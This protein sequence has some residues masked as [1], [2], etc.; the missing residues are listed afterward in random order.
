MKNNT[1]KKISQIPGTQ[2]KKKKKKLN[3]FFENRGNFNSGTS[4]L[5]LPSKDEKN[6]TS[7]IGVPLPSGKEEPLVV[8]R[9]GKTEGGANASYVKLD[10]EEGVF[11]YI[12]SVY[13]SK[14]KQ[15]NKQTENWVETRQSQ[16][17]VEEEKTSGNSGD[18]DKCAV[19]SE[20]AKDC[21]LSQLNQSN[22][23]K[24]SDEK[25]EE[26][27]E[28]ETKRFNTTTWT[29]AGSGVC[30]PIGTL[31]TPPPCRQCTHLQLQLDDATQKCKELEKKMDMLKRENSVFVSLQLDLA[32]KLELERVHAEELN[33]QHTKDTEDLHEQIRNSRNE[34]QI[35]CKE[36]LQM[37]Q[38]NDFLKQKVELYKNLDVTKA[39]KN[40]A[41]LTTIECCLKDNRTEYIGLRAFVEQFIDSMNEQFKLLKFP[42]SYKTKQ[43]KTKQYYTS[44]LTQLAETVF[45]DSNCCAQ[46]PQGP[47]PESATEE[48]VSVEQWNQ[49]HQQYKELSQQAAQLEELYLNEKEHRKK[50]LEQIIDLK[51]NIRVFCRVRP[52]IKR[53]ITPETNQENAIAV[54]CVDDERKEM[55]KFEFDQMFHQYADQAKIFEE[56]IPL[57]ASVMNGY[58]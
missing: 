19:G 44:K 20:N 24:P 28:E 57:I 46:N 2:K 7:D 32:K 47:A 43:N 16:R 13:H 55:K 25:E 11:I 39:T 1:K 58:N 35:L 9:I 3:V 17:F 56:V 26:E 27:E 38:A 42:M 29:V 52:P 40:R 31:P 54:S 18:N 8:S 21:T 14:N 41:R 15:T 50:L 37:K 45:G 51:G 4:L 23:K 6:T 34:I 5:T 30:N 12:L 22:R 49:L 33:G 48:R 53:D 36:L 10:K